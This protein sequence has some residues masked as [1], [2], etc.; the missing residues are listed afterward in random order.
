MATTKFIIEVEIDE[1]GAVKDLNKLEKGVKDVGQQADKTSAKTKGLKKG[2][3]ALKV[4]AVAAVAGFA[5]LVKGIKDSITAFGI[6]EDAEKSLEVA[7]GF[8]S[9]ALLD[10]AAAL[11]QVSTFGDEQIIQA[12]ALIAAFVDEEDQIAAA[13]KATVSP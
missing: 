5:L 6:Q 9:Q 2:L 11:Q 3:G 13:T 1:K 7:L 12:Q 8:T 4:G 10:Q